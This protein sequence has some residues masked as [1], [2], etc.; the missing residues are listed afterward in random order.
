MPNY[1]FSG[2]LTS[3]RTEEGLKREELAKELNCSVSAIA[4]YEN[5]NRKPDFD[6]LILLAD[7]FNTTTDYLLCR[8][9]VKNPNADIRAICEYTGLSELSVNRLHRFQSSEVSEEI[10]ILNRFLDDNYISNY[11]KIALNCYYMSHELSFAEYE[12]MKQF[13]E[14][15]GLISKELLNSYMEITKGTSDKIDMYLFKVQQLSLAEIRDISVSD[16]ET[17]VDFFDNILRIIKMLLI[18]KEEAN[19]I[20]SEDCENYKK[21]LVLSTNNDV[22]FPTIKHFYN[23]SAKKINDGLICSDDTKK[24]FMV[25]LKN[26]ITE[27]ENFVNS[28]ILEYQKMDGEP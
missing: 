21:I 2:R 12:F 7:F 10:D 20:T 16:I 9:N 1:T 23:E 17:R 28:K 19:E 14:N 27:F 25:I 13:N 24:K 5:G 6:T 18:A 22:L 3:L 11:S 15:N 8:T 4:N 26:L